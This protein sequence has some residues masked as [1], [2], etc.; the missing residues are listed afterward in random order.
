MAAGQGRGYNGP[1]KPLLALPLLLLVASTAAARERVLLLDRSPL[2]LEVGPRRQVLD[3][4]QSAL[5]GG[6][7]LVDRREGPAPAAPGPAIETLLA[8][9]KGQSEQF[10]EQQALQT[11]G[12]AEARFRAGFGRE[13][14]VKP[15]IHVLLARARLNADLGRRSEM[16]QDLGRALV[17]EPT[18]SL[19]PGLFPPALVQAARR[20]REAVGSR[21]AALSVRSTPTGQTVWVDGRSRGAAPLTIQLPAGEHFI[22]VGSR[23]A[24]RG[25]AISLT[26][27]A[28]AEVT[29]APR[30][31][32][33]L[34]DQRLRNMGQEADASWVV[35]LYLIERAGRYQV[36]V[37]AL[38]SRVVE[39]PRIYKGEAVPADRLTW[40]TSQVAV[41]LQS[42]L[43][44][45]AASSGLEPLRG[46][47]E[48]REG[49]GS[50]L[51]SWWFWTAVV[52]VVGGGTAA[53]V[54]L[55]RDSDPGVR[56]TLER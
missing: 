25:R 55:T 12:A 36:R 8:R 56:V 40:A 44:G 32:E 35:C 51:T 49:R 27:G 10:Q 53:A 46:P 45:P 41:Q 34:T 39:L 22:A 6:G 48:R 30:S 3:G 33:R 2:S 1:V 17:L 18:L 29:V 5:E 43:G 23:G 50:I 52:A 19:D 13:V 9:A 26:S 42:G 15:L 16:E 11:L 20:L 38:A 54:V 7:Y 31:R 21:L 14:S 4:L 37:R 28:A 47:A 24:T